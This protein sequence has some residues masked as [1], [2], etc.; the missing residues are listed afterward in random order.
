MK[1]FWNDPEGLAVSEVTVLTCLP[2]YLFVGA[3]MA[4]AGEVSVN[5]VDFFSVLSYPI[6][7]A[8]A[9]QAIEQIG[10]PALGRRGQT[11]AL[12]PTY[13]PEPYY[14][15]EQPNYTPRNEGDVGENTLISSQ[16][17]PTI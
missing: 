13:T 9:K 1:G 2:L 11:Q 4:F 14:Q 7:A 8:I 6:I 3:K 5:Q 10:W 17:K 16:N 12:Q 15:P